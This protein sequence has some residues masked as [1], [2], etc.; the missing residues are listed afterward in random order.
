MNDF[1]WGTLQQIAPD[2]VRDIV[3][4]AMVMDHVGTTAPIGRRML[5]GY[6]GLPEREVR[7]ADALRDEG[8]LI[9]QPTG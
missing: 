8:L 7:A 1:P 4:R 5:S 6:L 2:Q 3:C 9:Y